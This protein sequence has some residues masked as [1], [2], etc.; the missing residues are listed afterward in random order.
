MI[1]QIVQVYSQTKLEGTLTYPD[2]TKEKYPALLIIPGTGT[3][4]RDGNDPKG[5]LELHLYKQLATFFSNLGFITLRYDKRGVGKSE[6]EHIR[7]GFWDLVDDAEVALDYLHTQSKIDS[8]TIFV[9]GHSEGST[10]APALY[11]RKPFAGM[12]LLAGGGEKLEEA[13]NRQRRLALEQLQQSKGFKGKL[14]KWLHVIEKDEKKNKELM[15]KIKA[16]NT[17]FIRIQGFFKFPAKWMR[18]HLAYDLFEDLKKVKCPVLAITGDK[19]FQADASKLE[20]L[21]EYVQGPVDIHTIEDMD[22]SMKEYKKPIDV[23]N[24]KK[25]Y[26]ANANKDIHPEAQVLLKKWVGYQLEGEVAHG[27]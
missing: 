14:I 19:D 6:G 1:E 11:A 15:E 22:H 3:L 12:I 5:K 2:Q 9:L 20:R 24:F 4:N 21:P 10:L 16:S 18:E 27:K 26:I 8:D 17:D 7:T 25:D 13:L 23:S